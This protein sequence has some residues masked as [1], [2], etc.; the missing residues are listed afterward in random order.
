LKGKEMKLETARKASLEKMN[1]HNWLA[2]GFLSSQIRIKVALQEITKGRGSLYD[3]K[4][5]DV[6]LALFGKGFVLPD[7]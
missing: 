5:V 1:S 7:E 6:C 4:A 3:P 2:D